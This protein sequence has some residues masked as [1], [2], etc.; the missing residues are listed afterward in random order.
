M[1]IAITDPFGAGTA[2]QY[3]VNAACLFVAIPLAIMISTL[4]GDMHPE[5]FGG[6]ER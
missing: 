2:A 3:A 4:P 6:R 5:L 1:L